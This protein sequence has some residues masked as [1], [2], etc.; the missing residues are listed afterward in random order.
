MTSEALSWRDEGVHVG[1]DKSV[2]ALSDFRDMGSKRRRHSTVRVNLQLLHKEVWSV[3]WPCLRP[4]KRPRRAAGKTPNCSDPPQLRR[5]STFG[6]P[7]AHYAVGLCTVGL[8]TDSSLGSLSSLLW[9]ISY[10]LPSVS[11]MCAYARTSSICTPKRNRPVA[12]T[13]AALGR[14]FRAGEGLVQ[15][16]PAESH[17]C[18]EQ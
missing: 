4:A 12:S 7:Q 18:G 16:S 14:G 1:L 2:A 6:P 13:P 15:N 10:L 11:L 8:C 3:L 17:S 9:A 5:R